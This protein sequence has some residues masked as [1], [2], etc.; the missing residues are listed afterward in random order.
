MKKHK[1]VLIV[2]SAVIVV[3]AVLLVLSHLRTAE[4]KDA[5]AFQVQNG[6]YRMDMWLDSKDVDSFLEPYGTSSLA[7]LEE[8][9]SIYQKMNRNTN[10]NCLDELAY[11]TNYMCLTIRTTPEDA[12]PELKAAAEAAKGYLLDLAPYYK[13]LLYREDGTKYPSTSSGLLQGS[14]RLREAMN[15]DEYRTLY[16]EMV[17]KVI[18]TGEPKDNSSAE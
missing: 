5:V 6:F 17:E 2:Q 9:V 11:M 16:L 15:A 14:E 13:V 18:H 12:E 10:L 1:I 4:T 7:V 3:L 8:D